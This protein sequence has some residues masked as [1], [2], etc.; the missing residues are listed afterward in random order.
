[1]RVPELDE[2]LGSEATVIQFFAHEK[3]R[4]YIEDFQFPDEW[5][6]DPGGKHRGQWRHRTGFA[7][8]PSVRE[9]EWAGKK[10][11][12]TAVH[13]GAAVLPWICIG[14]FCL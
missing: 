1:M 6:D 11:A 7:G 8:L 12:R 14:N 2:L 10:A 13:A 5:S 9:G 4:L 3:R